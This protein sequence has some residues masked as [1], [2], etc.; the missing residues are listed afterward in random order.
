MTLVQLKEVL[1]YFFVGG[2]VTAA[3]VMLEKSD[4]RLLSGLATLMP[5][6]TLVAYVFIGESKGGIAVS[7]HSWLVLVGTLVSWVPYMLVVALAAPK[8]GP[9]KAIPAGLAVFF[10]CA[11]AYLSVVKRFGLFNDRL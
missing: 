4:S 2:A 8:Y 6:F 11:V 1:L 10:A 7:Q 5:V 3:I 9:H